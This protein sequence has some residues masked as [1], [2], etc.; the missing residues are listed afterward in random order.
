M[1]GI[2]S[3]LD[4]ALVFANALLVSA[5]SATPPQL[6]SPSYAG[7]VRPEAVLPD[8]ALCLPTFSHCWIV[9]KLLSVTSR[10]SIIFSL[11]LS[12]SLSLFSSSSSFR[13]RHRQWPQ[14]QRCGGGCGNAGW[15]H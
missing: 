2:P 4:C 3:P 10:L 7:H 11:S 1:Q 9:N 8:R 12:L 15:E 14:L 13:S 5:S 6:Y